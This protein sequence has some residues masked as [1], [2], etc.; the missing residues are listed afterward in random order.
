MPFLPVMIY[1]TSNFIFPDPVPAMIVF[2]DS[3][4]FVTVISGD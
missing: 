2:V 1:H 4:C 3:G